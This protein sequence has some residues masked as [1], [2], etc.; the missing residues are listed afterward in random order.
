MIFRGLYLIGYPI[1]LALLFVLGVFHRKVRRGL[2]ARLQS[3]PH[4]N[5]MGTEVVWFHAASSGELEQAFPIMDRLKAQ[6]PEAKIHLSYFSPTGERA[7]ELE[8]A[9][10]KKAGRQ[11]CWD[12]LGFSPFDLPGVVRRRLVAMRPLCLVLIHRE[13]WPELT[14]A[15]IKL[16]VP[17]IWVDVSLPKGLP[18]WLAAC[19]GLWSQFT[20][21]GAVDEASAKLLPESAMVGDSRVDRLLDRQLFY[22]DGGHCASKSPQRPPS[23]AGRRVFLAA[24]IWPEDWRAI[25][26]GVFELIRKESGYE[27]WLVPHE[28]HQPFLEEIRNDFERENISFSNGHQ[29]ITTVGHLAELYRYSEIV[30]VGGSFRGRVHNVLEPA[31]YSKPV[32]TGPK[33]LNSVEACEFRKSGALLSLTAEDFAPALLDLASNAQKRADMADRLRTYLENHRGA[34]ERYAKLIIDSL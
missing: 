6:R 21:I 14:R 12:S 25:R 10:R 20:A 15:A 17:V 31:V 32:L 28:M 7:V 26:R 16:G 30:F 22:G 29:L 11:N 27:V 19:R 1:F 18:R 23:P 3:P 34:S 8:A 13:I 5:N 24:S 2:I 4:N 9:R 33:V